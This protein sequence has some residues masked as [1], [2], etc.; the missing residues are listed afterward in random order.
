MLAN[1]VNAYIT[2]DKNFIFVFSLFFLSV[3]LVS[4]IMLCMRKFK[5]VPIGACIINEYEKHKSIFTTRNYRRKSFLV[6]RKKEIF[7]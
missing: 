2:D 4:D 6:V 3:V 1:D 5:E 7:T